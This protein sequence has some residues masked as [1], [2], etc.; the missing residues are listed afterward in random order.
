MNYLKFLLS[1]KNLR[2]SSI[3]QAQCQHN[4]HPFVYE[5]FIHI[6]MNILYVYILQ[7]GGRCCG[8]GR[9]IFSIDGRRAALWVA[10]QR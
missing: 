7:E 9:Y 1:P 8:G 4:F 2:F 6:Y 10:E 3:R 5:Y